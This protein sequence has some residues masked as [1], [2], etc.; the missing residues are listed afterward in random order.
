MDHRAIGVFDSGLGGLTAAKVLAETLPHENLIYF[1]DSGRMPYGGR[2]VEELQDIALSDAAFVS[3]FDVKAILVACGTMSACAM[4]TLRRGFP[5]IPFFSVEDAACDAVVAA[6]QTRR[7][8]VIATAG[9]IQNGM[10]ERGIKRRDSGIEVIAKACPSLA[11]I[12]E[13]GHFRPGDAVAEAAVRE[14]LAVFENSGIDT[15]LLGCTH[16]P[17]L[18]DIIAGYLG[19]HVR[20]IS[21]GAE[22]AAALADYLRDHALLNGSDAPGQRLWYTSGDPELFAAGAGVFLGYPIEAR[23]HIL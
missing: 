19:E 2:S 14:E 12:V 8:G 7:V 6:T 4:D 20:Q 9:S 5:A 3:S 18:G 11:G 13:Q 17:L 16:Y 1:G 22:T 15:L 10:F 23:Q 21:C